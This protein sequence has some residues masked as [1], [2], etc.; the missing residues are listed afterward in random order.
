VR[1]ALRADLAVQRAADAG[2]DRVLK[3]NCHYRQELREF[4]RTYLRRIMKATG[5]RVYLT[6]RVSGISEGN[7][8]KMITMLNLKAEFNRATCRYGRDDN[9]RFARPETVA[10][11]QNSKP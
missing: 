2:G 10:C 3:N 1:E 8:H 5:N 7:I 9:G 11:Q 4:Q 6:A